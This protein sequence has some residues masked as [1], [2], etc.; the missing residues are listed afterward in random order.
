MSDDV[1]RIVESVEA[2]AYADLLRAAPADWRCL[3]EQLDD[4]CLLMAPSIDVLL[5]NRVL[6]AGV[7]APVSRPALAAAVA[8]L[9][10]CGLRNYGVQIAPNG[11][12]ADVRGWL[13]GTGLFPRDR[14]TKV[15]RGAE[16]AASIATDL[17]VTQVSSGQRDL[18]AEVVTAGFGMP[19]AW[20]PLVA[21]TVGRARWHHY[22]AWSRSEPVA[23]AALFVEGAVGW[24][25]VASTVRDARRR[26]AQ[27]AL[28]ARR[29]EDGR[30]L[31]CR[32]F[33][34]ETGE[35]TEAR[36]NPS[37]RNMMRAGFTVVHHRQ[38]FM[39]D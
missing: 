27:S 35:E 3:A 10:A 7:G 37:Y 13:A 9:Q 26:G 30:A 8:R 36:P 15:C 16:P 2:A 11:D 31:G 24:L 18:F 29:I 20:R 5:F 1:S 39:P 34:T 33:A 14:W 17:S 25:G 23:G 32:W 12:S 38:N 4:L 28:M 19:A 6:G 22:L 21:N